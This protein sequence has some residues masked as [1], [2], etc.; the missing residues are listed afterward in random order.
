VLNG[1]WQTGF[2]LR[3]GGDLYLTMCQTQTRKQEQ[4]FYQES[5]STK[6]KT[7]RDR[8]YDDKWFREKDS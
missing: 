1:W 2:K 4:S 5:Q 6:S 3:V 8:N 7:G